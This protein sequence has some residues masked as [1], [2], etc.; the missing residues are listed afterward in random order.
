MAQL[1]TDIP[2][3]GSVSWGAMLAAHRSQKM[4]FFFFKTP[5]KFDFLENS[6]FIIQFIL[7]NVCY[8]HACV[9]VNEPPM[10]LQDDLM[11]TV[12]TCW[13]EAEHVTIFVL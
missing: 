12:I 6:L 7:E 8:W 3:C 11:S 2:E 9:Y 13:S 10:V 1:K 5:K 4:S